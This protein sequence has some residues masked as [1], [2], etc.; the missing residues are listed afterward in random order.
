MKSKNKFYGIMEKSNININSIDITDI[1]SLLIKSRY[2]DKFALT[3][4]QL[5]ILNS[6]SKYH[7]FLYENL[8]F[9]EAITPEET[10]KK[11]KNIISSINTKFNIKIS[12]KELFKQYIFY[13][14]ANISFNIFLIG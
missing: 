8:E 10:A 9:N 14:K 4:E 3:E 1:G 12:I 5:D 2:M 6:S 7:Q 13:T 11:Y